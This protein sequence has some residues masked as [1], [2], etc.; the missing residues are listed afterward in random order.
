MQP[1]EDD[2]VHRARIHNTALILAAVVVVIAGLRAA[3]EILVPFLLAV[4]LSALAI[5]PLFWLQRRQVPTVPAVVLV[6]SVMVLILVL[7]AAYV[8][9][10]INDFLGE[11]PTYRERLDGQIQ[12]LAAWLDDYGIYLS[13][14]ALRQYV[15][16]GQAFQL[17][18]DTLRGLGGV[19][20]NA[21]VIL[22]TV[23]FILLEA[24]A[25]PAKLH[26]AFNPEG[27]AL[28][29]FDTFAES[30][31]EYLAIK[32]LVSLITGA[33]ITLWL[34]MVGLDFPF[35]WGLVAFLLNFIPNIGSLIAAIPAV[36]LA[37]VQ[38]GPL[39]TL[40]VV[41][42]YGL[43]N[44]VAGNFLEP[45]LMGAGLGLSTL[46]V[47][48]SL[49]FWGWVLGPVGMLL[50]VPLTMILKIALDQRSDTRWLAVLLGR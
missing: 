34:L 6:M 10:A 5:P 33:T 25:F 15:D 40:W 50:S 23:V 43:V 24:A 2:G 38:L 11:L 1:T 44:A 28:R 49:F 17:L 13:V 18:G 26:R 14:D 22:V 41:L 42:G 47:V 21:F 48:L 39:A 8:G 20:S 9:A 12:A 36:L 31:Q 46:V 29:F 27:D 45:R 30:V 3:G 32:T 35:L 19:L 7:L 4:F 37:L 16:P